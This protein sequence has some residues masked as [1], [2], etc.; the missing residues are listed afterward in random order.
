[1]VEWIYSK[2]FKLGT[3]RYQLKKQRLN[4]CFLGSIIFGVADEATL[5][6]WHKKRDISSLSCYNVIDQEN[7]RK[8]GLNVSLIFY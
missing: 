2:L 8:D 4:R 5:F 1:M 7:N 3:S 6:S